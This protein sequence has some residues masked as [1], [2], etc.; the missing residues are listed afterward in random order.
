[1][2]QLKDAS[3]DSHRFAE[4]S[5]PNTPASGFGRLFFTTLGAYWINSA[6]AVLPIATFKREIFIPAYQMWPSTTNGS[7]AITKT[8]YTT[9]DQDLQSLD[10]D[11]T[12]QEHAQFTLVMPDDWNAGTI[13]FK[14]WWTAAAGSA[15]QTVEWNLQARAYANDDAIDAAWGTAIEVSDA[16]IATGDIH[17]TSESAELTIA[18][19]PSAGELVQFR[20]YRDIADTLAAD[21]RLL[22]IKIYYY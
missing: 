19:T 8:E 6:A 18:N 17:V 11:Q 13:T 14:A 9:N 2:P 12:T 4:G 5:T 21:A 1:M 22:G 20:V 15:A 7:S 10:F 16:L 3:T